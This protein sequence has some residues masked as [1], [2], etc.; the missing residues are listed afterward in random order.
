MPAFT[1][2]A[3]Y[4]PAGDQGKAIEAIARAFGDPA[5]ERVVLLGATGTGKTYTMAAAIERLQRPTLILAHNKTLAAQLCNELREFFP[6]NAIEYFVSY[7]DYYQPEAY[8]PSTDTYIEKTSAINDDID[9]LRHSAT[10]SLLERRDTVVV[11][12]ISCI[13]GLG[14]PEEYAR[15]A[16]RVHVGETISRQALLRALVSVYYERNDIDLGRGRFRV[17]GDSVEL[18]PS[19]EESVVRIELFG[20]E[21]D[22]IR[23]IDPV[24]GEILR[25]IDQVTIFPAKH[26][27]TPEEDLGR[28]LR[29]IETEL[30]DRLGWF[31]RHQKLLEAQRIE[32]RTRYDLEMLRQI[33]Q[34]NGVENYSRH[35]GGR[36][37]GEPPATLL[38][39][40][41]KDFLL[42]IDESH[43]TLPQVQAMYAGDRSRK[44]VLVDHGFRLPSALDNR[45]LQAAEFWQR[46]GQV[47]YV[48]AT[49]GDREMKEAGANVVEQ[50]IRPTGLLD[51]TIEVR[52]VT[53]QVD[54]L[55]G[56]I[57]E[58]T[59]RGHRV[60]VTTL[61]KRMAED[62][63]DY[64]LEIGLKARY[65]HSDVKSLERIALLRDLRQGVFD[66]LVGVNLL[67]EGLD[68]PE[69][70]LVAILDADKEGYLR[71]GRSLIQTMGRAARHPEGHVLMYA[72]RITGSMERAIEET[73]RR[74]KLQEAHNEAHGIVPQ[75]IVKS[76]RNALLEA[77]GAAPEVDP[78]TAVRPE[79]IPAA[80][81][82]LEGEMRAAAQSLEFEHAAE[83]RDRI[84]SLRLQLAEHGRAQAQAAEVLGTPPQD[85]PGARRPKGRRS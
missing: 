53:G 46:V 11:A 55:V 82:R 50:I 85:T 51:P 1:L 79:D 52:P 27:V 8:I 74:R 33:G 58:R 22:R 67:R 18:V 13:Y 72:D 78:A 41:P 60:L 59:G 30:D 56:V 65:L 57:R 9:R 69:V 14:P 7:Y 23:V 2:K 62:L 39:Y 47:M 66:I 68:L 16:R 40:F 43:V 75:P 63:T 20:D 64:M 29:D 77:L 12:S 31:M 34:C 28:A 61:T 15:G 35:L 44:T 48:S 24:T 38:S 80:I 25:D 4:G 71:D 83:L 10:R 26:F 3:P 42:F 49:P 45:P 17:R 54:H 36:R 19:Y 21:V 76:S 73:S 37:E 84:Q 6:D 70:S 81:K 5:T 32:Q